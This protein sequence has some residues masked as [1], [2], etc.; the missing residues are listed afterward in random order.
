MAIIVVEKFYDKWDVGCCP[1]ET[2][3]GAEEDADNLRSAFEKNYECEVKVLRR[4]DEKVSR[5]EIIRFIQEI[6][7]IMS[8]KNCRY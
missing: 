8:D 4:P 3:V 6:K 7:G 2:R 1:P 5:K